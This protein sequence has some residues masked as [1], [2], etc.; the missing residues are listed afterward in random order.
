MVAAMVL[1]AAACS[2]GAP[3]VSN[4]GFGPAAA[5]FAAEADRALDGSRFAEVPPDDLANAIVTLCASGGSI[6]AVIQGLPAPRGD[7]DD[8]LIVREV[9]LTGLVQVCP[10]QTGDSSVVEAYLASVRT[11][12]ASA[13]A[14]LVLDDEPLIA[15]GTVACASLDAEGGAEGAALSAAAILFD[16]ERSTIEELESVLDEPQGIAVGATLAAAA[17]YFCP[18]HEQIVADLVAGA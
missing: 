4:G 7:P 18:E 3:E 14:D 5:R 15:A 16:V 1:I 13:G 12:I 8:D 9:I 6:E 2:T 11:A 17:A 10:M